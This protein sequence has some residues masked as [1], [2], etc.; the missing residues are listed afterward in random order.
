MTKI[1]IYGQ[2]HTRAGNQCYDVEITD[3]GL[4]IH[5]ETELEN[6]DVSVYDVSEEEIDRIEKM[7]DLAGAGKDVFLLKVANTLRENLP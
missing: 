6:S 4:A 3:D 1:A 7:V 2:H 5:P